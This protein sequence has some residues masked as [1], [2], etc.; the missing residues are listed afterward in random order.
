MTVFLT[1][2][3]MEEAAESI[4][5]TIERLQPIQKETIVFEEYQI[6]NKF[7]YTYR[8]CNTSSCSNL[9]GTY[10]A[11]KNYKVLKIA[12]A[13]D[14]YEGKDM[15]DFSSK[16]GKINYI[17]NNKS[18]SVEIKSPIQKTY[19]GKYL[20]IKVPAALE[21]SQSIELEYTVRNKN[22]VYKLR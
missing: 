6:L 8:I 1:T 12:F 16:Y 20:Y 11:P 10:T 7:D 14:T 21:T 4:E 5:E 22:Y 17:D 2:Q 18:K 13:S 15:I 19:Y 9:Y 3:Y